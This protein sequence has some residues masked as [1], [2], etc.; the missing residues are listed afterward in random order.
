MSSCKRSTAE[1]DV[2]IECICHQKIVIESGVLR[3][4]IRAPPFQFIFFKFF[5][6]MGG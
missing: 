4:D 1:I 6:R 5:R 2:T 3:S